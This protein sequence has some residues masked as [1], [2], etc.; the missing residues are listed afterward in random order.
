[1]QLMVVVFPDPLGPRSPNTS[2]FSIFILKLSRAISSLYLLTR[3]LTSTI[4]SDI[5][6]VLL[7]Q[8]TIALYT[9]IFPCGSVK[10]NEIYM[11]NVT[12]AIFML[13]TVTPLSQNSLRGAVIMRSDNILPVHSITGHTSREYLSAD[14]YVFLSG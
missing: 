1:M 5:F 10:C 2:P 11:T 6:I 12:N 13:Y 7:F 14:R 9:F 3:F 8:F 4:V